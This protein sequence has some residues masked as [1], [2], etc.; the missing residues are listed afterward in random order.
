MSQQ[1]TLSMPAGSSGTSP[2]GGGTYGGLLV[3][4]NGGSKFTPDA[5]TTTCVASL[6]AGG[7][8]VPNTDYDLQWRV[9]SSDKGCTA[10]VS[11]SSTDKSFPSNPAKKYS[12]NAYFLTGHV[13]AQGT[14]I[15][16]TLTFS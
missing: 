4:A 13:P 10:N 16:L 12:F 11:G 7:A 5:G 8:A 3:F 6:T 1:E 9:S 2:C 15:V 14:S